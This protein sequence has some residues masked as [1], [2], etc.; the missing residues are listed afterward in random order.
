MKSLIA[1]SAQ[2][3]QNLASFCNLGRK[4]QLTVRSRDVSKS[5]QTWEL[6]NT[7]NFILKEWSKIK[8]REIPADK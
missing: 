1:I 8:S 7:T 5:L 3:V 2:R 6:Q 4:K